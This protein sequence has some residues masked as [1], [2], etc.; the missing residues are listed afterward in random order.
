MQAEAPPP[1]NYFIVG[2]AIP[3]LL[4]ACLVCFSP[5]RYEIVA[6]PPNYFIVGSYQLLW[7]GLRPTTLGEP[8]SLDYFLK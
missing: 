7:G 1:P 6:P 5:L 8:C 4:G 3:R 2:F